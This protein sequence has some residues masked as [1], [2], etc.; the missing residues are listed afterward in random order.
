M[1]IAKTTKRDTRKATKADK[2]AAGGL[3]PSNTC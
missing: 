1:I 2:A 3:T